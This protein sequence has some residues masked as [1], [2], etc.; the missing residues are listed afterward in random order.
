MV[1]AGY[2]VIANE[3]LDGTSSGTRS[4]DG[5]PQP[6]RQPTADELKEN[7]A[8]ALRNAQLQHRRVETM[9]VLDAVR[10]APTP[11]D[12]EWLRIVRETADVSRVFFVGHSFGGAQVVEESDIDGLVGIVALD[13][14]LLPLSR[15][16]LNAAL[17]VPSLFLNTE[18]QWAKNV[19]RMTNLRDRA[20]QR[21]SVLLL[22]GT[23]HQAV[24][25]FPY[26]F[27]VLRLMGGSGWLGAE[28]S[29]RAFAA[30]TVAFLDNCCTSPATD[31][32]ELENLLL[33]VDS[34]LPLKVQ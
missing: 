21:S 32:H 12:A 10:A 4:P 24:S 33:A 14:W 7:E 19:A 22:A 25:D 20:T 9:E 29:L 1:D 18:F 5:T 2:T 15:D 3:S 27:P 17:P 28:R 8:Y 11:H 30:L 13:S 23:K 34:T 6:Y 31:R 26:F 16:K